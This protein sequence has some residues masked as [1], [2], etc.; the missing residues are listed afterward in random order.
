MGYRVWKAYQE[1]RVGV[2][3]KTGC[4]EPEPIQPALGILESSQDVAPCEALVVGGVTIRSE[5]RLNHGLLMAGQEARRV[6]IVVDEEVGPYG[7]YDSGQAFLYCGETCVRLA[8]V[9][10]R[11]KNRRHHSQG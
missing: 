9:R 2:K 6:G 1:Q 3:R 10:A 4:V 8:R 5:P 7:D 11:I